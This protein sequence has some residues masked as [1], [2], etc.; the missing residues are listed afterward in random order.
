MKT[1]IIS[2]LLIKL[3]KCE[4]SDSFEMINASRS[5]DENPSSEWVKI[6]NPSDKNISS[7]YEL[8]E[9]IDPEISQI[10]NFISKQTLKSDGGKSTTLSD[11][12]L[13]IND[14]KERIIRGYIEKN[15]FEK[16]KNI[17]QKSTC[18]AEVNSLFYR[19]KSDE[20]MEKYGP[21]S[22][23]YIF[24][25]VKNH[26][27]GLV[28]AFN[29]IYKNF[30]NNYVSLLSKMANKLN[31]T[32][33]PKDISNEFAAL[34]N[35]FMSFYSGKLPKEDKLPSI[36]DA[37]EAFNKSLNVFY[38]VFS[39]SPVPE[40]SLPK[41][42]IPDMYSLIGSLF[43]NT[44]TYGLSKKT[45]FHLICLLDGFIDIFKWVEV[46]SNLQVGQ[47]NEKIDKYIQRIQLDGFIGHKSRE[48][49]ID[50]LM[51]A[52]TDLISNIE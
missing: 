9:N 10:G 52:L 4:D 40:N 31:F 43:K 8:A 6:G 38:S 24:L 13:S 28:N 49:S 39:N 17:I 22:K 30:M 35:R 36:K 14:I 48:E 19:F 32:I 26:Y 42:F 33:Q 11:V 20:I 46:Y 29:E 23:A 1:S 18:P 34:N 3:N 25:L 7:E 12:F 21:N 51:N 37:F 50:E 15:E 16:M 45:Q 47:N 2:I 44:D 41:S 5:S 27:I